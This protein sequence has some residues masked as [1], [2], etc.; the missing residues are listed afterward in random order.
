VG[1][2]AA[3]VLGMGWSETGAGAGAGAGRGAG[4]P[5]TTGDG[6]A[7]MRTDSDELETSQSREIGSFDT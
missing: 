4:E 7:D 5:E 3:L 2:V 1:T 6:C